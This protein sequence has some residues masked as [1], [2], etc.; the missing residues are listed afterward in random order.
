MPQLSLS[1]HSTILFEV[2]WMNKL[3]AVSLFVFLMGAVRKVVG[4]E[5]GVISRLRNQ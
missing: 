5:S 3:A 2:L 4:I 1:L